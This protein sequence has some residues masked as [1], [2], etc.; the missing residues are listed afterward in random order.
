[1][2]LLRPTE[3]ERAVIGILAGG[4]AQDTSSARML[5]P[6]DFCD[7]ATGRIFAACLHLLTQ[8]KPVSLPALDELLT[9]EYGADQGGELMQTVMES[10]SRYRL[11]G[12]QLPE[13]VR[14]V[15]EGAQR[16]N[17]V[18]IGEAISK[19]AS[20]DQR[21]MTELVDKA[22]NA[23]RGSVVGTA[24][25]VDAQTAILNAYEAVER[26]EKPIPTGIRELDVRVLQGGLHRGEMTVLG[27]RPGV[28][29][30]AVMLQM[31]VEAAMSGKH[32]VFVSLEMSAEQIGARLIGRFAGENICLLRG[33]AMP[34]EQQW[35][36]LAEASSEAG[37]AI[38]ERLKLIVR[39]GMTIEELTSEVIGLHDN[40]EC[41]LLVVDY[42]QILRSRQKTGNELERLG[43]VSR[44]LKAITLDLNIPILTA[45]Q[46]RRQNNGGVARAPSLDELRGSSDIEQD[47][48]N[49]ILLH[50]PEAA[51]DSALYRAEDVAMWSRAGD[52]GKRVML[53]NVAKQRQGITACAW[54]VF[55]PSRMRFESPE[56]FMRKEVS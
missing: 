37:I 46:V 12:W 36:V 19:G 52:A 38:G 17:L 22:R 4:T 28:G 20:D 42:L 31:A 5:S 25:V 53:F 6:E 51:D 45:A 56:E 34:T 16:R 10:S 50:S 1:M 24:H 15:R 55:D 44:G 11:Q 3:H 54:A 47:A 49:V 35:V 21:D 33:G 2:D 27:A 43:I 32:V 41:D 8:H 18:R 30:S 14:L 13:A 39:G 40:G 26:A 48:D 9:K 29:K 7:R 23:L